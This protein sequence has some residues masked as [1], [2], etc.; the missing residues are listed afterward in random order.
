VHSNNA[1]DRLHSP[2]QLLVKILDVIHDD[3]ASSRS[4]A[5]VVRNDP[6]TVARLIAL[7]NSRAYSKAADCTSI[8]SAISLLG[9]E[10]VKTIVV[11]T[12]RK[13]LL[14][15][16]NGRHTVFLKKHWQSSLLTAQLSLE[17]ASLTNYSSPDEAYVSGLL[18]DIGQLVLL[19]QNDG[20]SLRPLDA[21][22][23][24]S[25]RSSAESECCPEN[26]CAIGA[27]LFD[28]WQINPFITNAIRHHRDKPDA[29]QGAH[30]LVKLTKLAGLLIQQHNTAQEIDTEELR[31][32]YR[33]LG[34]NDDITRELVGRVSANVGQ[35][36][37]D[38]GVEP[39]KENN[40]DTEA[41]KILVERL[42][43]FADI[44]QISHLFSDGQK[45]AGSGKALRSA[46]LLTGNIPNALLFLYRDDQQMLEAYLSDHQVGSA[47]F[48]IPAQSNVSVISDCYVE[49]SLRTVS[50]SEP[51]KIVDRQ[52]TEHI[53]TQSLICV[54]LT[55]QYQSVGV[56]ALGHYGLARDEIE[57]HPE[58]LQLLAT[59]IARRLL[60]SRLT[61][62]QTE[63]RDVNA[64]GVDLRVLEAVHEVS[65]PLTIILNYLEIL[66]M[67]SG[68]WG[69]DDGKIERI[70]EEVEGIKN[71]LLRI[72]SPK[73]KETT[74]ERLHQ[75]I[76]SLAEA[77]RASLPGTK[78]I[79]ILLSLD[80][81]TESVIVDSVLFRQVLT[82]LLKNSAEALQEGGKILIITENNI[83]VGGESYFAVYVHDDGP[84]I[85]SELRKSLFSPMKSTKG[86]GHSGL[87]LSIVKKMLDEIGGTIVCRSN[88]DAKIKA[89]GTQFQI[90][91][92]ISL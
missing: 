61:P 20:D 68:E 4:V 24:S 19:A 39:G 3:G 52:I 85:P 62:V 67:G 87:G 42:E 90:L 55:Y 33:L 69:E 84:G 59:E 54:P 8:D 46:L 9:L 2:A 82:N 25:P 73:S 65:N 63:A 14:E 51:I 48:R 17:L 53:G 50:L 79:D 86:V 81:E 32:S 47:D 75:V 78:R 45:N 70:K 13:Q 5:N 28:N 60:T 1:V 21:D 83:S 22:R 23:P 72:T 15:N 16:F 44:A 64:D 7:A 11:T 35:I 12:A 88:A 57:A 26:V 41:Q 27:G 74:T 37:I 76:E 30:Q 80:K 58:Y 40:K 49:Q 31:Q 77:F 43:M 66:R 36:A 89:T 71:I 18:A 10:A 92:P 34:L 6:A 56:L 38:Y 91:V 29:I